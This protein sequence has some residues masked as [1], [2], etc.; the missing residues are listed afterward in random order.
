MNLLSSEMAMKSTLSIESTNRRDGVEGAAFAGVFA[1]EVGADVAGGVFDL[2]EGGGPD[3]LLDLV[4]IFLVVGDDLDAAGGL[5]DALELHEERGLD[6]A[7][8][9]VALLG[10]GVGEID[11]DHRQ[12]FFS[13]ELA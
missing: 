9:V 4:K 1:L 3:D 8:L 13:D 11:V 2:L 6:E 12:G 7:A 10:P 5:E